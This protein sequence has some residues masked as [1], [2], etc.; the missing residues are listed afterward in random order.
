MRGV[1]A[2]TGR[3]LDG[4]GHLAQSITDILTT[5][6]GSR[7]MRRDYGSDVPALLDAP[8]NAQTLLDFRVAVAE[9]LQRWEP[10]VTLD[11][12]EVIEAG[13]DGLLVELSG[14]WTDRAA[15]GGATIEGA[16]AQAGAQE[17]TL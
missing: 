14:T 3:A 9:A 5:P 1:D 13:P 11:R 15:D 12:I 10:R 16:R 8:M 7:V 6:R 2:V 4:E 17:V